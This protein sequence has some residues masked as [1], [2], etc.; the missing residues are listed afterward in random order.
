MAPSIK[1]EDA[2]KSALS[3][4]KSHYENFPVVSFLIPK[5]LQKHV[6]II[7]WF[8]RTADDLADEGNVPEETRLQNLNAFETRLTS[9]LNGVYTDDFDKAL[10][11]TISEKKLTPSLFFDL[12]SAFKQDVTK[13]RYLNFGEMIDYSR[14]SANP[15]GRLIL[16]LFDIRDTEA[17]CLSDLICSALQFA[18]FVQDTGVDFN[19]GRIYLPLDEMEKFGVGENLFDLNEK[20]G[21]F[22]ELMK[23]QVDRIEKMFAEG[24]NL[25]KFLSGRLRFEIAWTLLGGMEILKKVKDI[26]YNVIAKRPALKKSDFI[27]LFCKAMVMR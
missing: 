10:G 13:K 26:N 8:A 11:A 1:T 20:I 9:L 25:L 3:F 22:E 23:F 14:R 12:L 6:A 4:A 15:V 21:N 16:E 19:K 5:Q 27:I 24:R 17:F 7:Y 2:Y 18:N